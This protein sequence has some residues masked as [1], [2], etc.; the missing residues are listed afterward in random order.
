MRG[1]RLILVDDHEVVRLGLMSL[2]EDLDWVQVVDEVGTA[3]AALRAVDAHRPDV[4]VMDIRLPDESGIEACRK[5]VDS[6]P[7]TKVI[8]LTSYADD[9]LIFKAIRAGASGYVLKQ[10]GNQELIRALE[11]VRRGDA[12]LDPAV[13]RRVLARMRE[14]ERQQQAGAFRDL[15]KRELQVLAQVAQ[16]KSNPQIASQISLSEKTVRNHVSAILAKLGLE[17]RV[18]AATFA[19]RHDIDQQQ[20]E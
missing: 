2:M 13:T 7:E 17:N 3:Q 8:M 1:I 19:V 14:S 9:E 15:S 20:L 4:V 11:A 18:E 10:V 5:I 16:G 12:L 6:W